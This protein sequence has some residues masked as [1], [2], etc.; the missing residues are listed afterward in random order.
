MAKKSLPPGTSPPRTREKASSS[1]LVPVPGQDRKKGRRQTPPNSAVKGSRKLAV[2]DRRQAERELE[3]ERDFVS[4]VLDTVGALV[5]VLDPDGRIV[6]FNR[7]CEKTT[8]YSFAEVRGKEFWDIFLTSEERAPVQ[9]VFEKLQQTG[10]PSEYENYWLTKRGDRRLIL[11]SNGTLRDE[12]GRVAYLIGTGVDITERRKAALALQTSERRT[13]ALLYAIPDMMFRISRDGEFLDFHAERAND[14]L[15]PPDQIVGLNIRQ[16]P[17]PPDV[18]QKSLDCIARA[19]ETDFP[20]LFEYR[21]ELPGGMRDY[22]ARIVRSGEDEVVSIVRDITERKRSEEV[23]RRQETEF[24]FLAD[25]VPGLFAYIGRDQR[26]RFVNKRY[27]E[28]H[29]LS[30]GEIIGKHIAEVI[31]KAGYELARPHL[32]A[33]LSG[34]RVTYEAQF[35]LA[36]GNRWM[37]VVYFPDL[38]EKEGSEVHGFFALITDITEPKMAEEALRALTARLISVQEENNRFLARELHDVFSQRL[39]ALG[40]EV[41]L[42]EPQ[43]EGCCGEVLRKVTEEIGNLA[44]DVHQ[45]SRQVHPSILDDLGLTAALRAE[46]AAF[47]RTYGIP[48]DFLANALEEMLPGDVSLCLYRVAQECLR[49]VARHAQ[50]EKASVTL[51]SNGS[52]VTLQV[53]DTGTGFDPGARKAQG[54]LG[55]VSMEE[56]V[57]LVKGILSVHSRPGEGTRIRIRVPISGGTA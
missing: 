24:R 43:V 18:I 22:E 54:E 53:E 30:R 55:L 33:V 42:L 50:A 20:Q 36:V 23:L 12:Q 3:S 44:K 13:R 19:L 21:L 15:L 29:H 25:N 6:R 46:C 1:A 39:A 37:H 56:R 45:L 38:S 16:S 32:E 2:A 10:L 27:E 52:V 4:A 57:R 41:S 17:H 31:G 5:V 14:L 26:Y 51:A 7:A 11:W 28:V 49:N 9:G 35:P 40:M 34:R 48:V 47:T 8:G